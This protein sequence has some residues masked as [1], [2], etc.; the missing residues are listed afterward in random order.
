LELA[1]KV[2]L[3]VKVKVTLEQAVK[4]QRGSRGIALFVL[5]PRRCKGVATQC[6]AP[7]A[8]PLV[9]TRYPLYRRL[10]GPGAGLYE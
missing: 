3:K 1:E 10:G 6:H 7:A 5:Q 9:K 2:K 4:S 8:L